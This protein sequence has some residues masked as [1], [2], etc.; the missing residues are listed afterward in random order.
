MSCRYCT[1]RTPPPFSP[2]PRRQLFSPLQPELC[3][4]ELRGSVRL[5]VSSHATKRR[6][7][8]GKRR[9]T[10]MRA[11]P[12]II[13][14]TCSRSQPHTNKQFL[15]VKSGAYIMYAD[16]LSSILEKSKQNSQTKKKKMGAVF[17]S[18]LQSKEGNRERGKCDH[19][20]LNMSWMPTNKSNYCWVLIS[21]IQPFQETPTD[22]TK[23][24]HQ[25]SGT[26]KVPIEFSRTLA[27]QTGLHTR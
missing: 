25:W 18:L 17:C 27:P 16:S 3:L 1:N 21:F 23:T 22:M 15:R 20:T 8:N 12:C 26:L 4:S 2:P 14:L 7:E 24:A 6:R 9:E 19:D 11:G 5:C 13:Q 10:D